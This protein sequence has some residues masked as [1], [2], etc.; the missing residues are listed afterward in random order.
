[1]RQLPLNAPALRQTVASAPLKAKR[2]ER[3]AAAPSAPR[4]LDADELRL[5]SGGAL[6]PKRTW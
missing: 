6:A 3:R 5:V 2:E 1:M 4:E